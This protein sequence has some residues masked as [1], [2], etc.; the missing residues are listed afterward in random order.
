MLSARGRSESA[1]SAL[2]AG[3]P[4]VRRDDVWGRVGG[5]VCRDGCVRRF[6]RSARIRPGGIG[7]GRAVAVWGTLERA[8][9]IEPA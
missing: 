3:D 9:G 4:G 7:V 1:V 5:W 6:V 2:P 8:T